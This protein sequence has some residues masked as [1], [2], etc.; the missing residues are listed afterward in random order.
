M[1]CSSAS[2]LGH[3]L[4]S[5]FQIHQKPLAVT[6]ASRKAAVAAVTAR[7]DSIPIQRFASPLAALRNATAV[8]FVRGVFT[9]FVAVAIGIL[10]VSGVAGFVA[11]LVAHLI[12]SGALLLRMKAAPSAYFVQQGPLGFL[13]SG[14]SDNLVL[15]IF[16]WT[17]AYAVVHVY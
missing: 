14:L 11:Y 4:A 10:G 8:G 2:S 6:M 15:F 12:A 7:S 13:F 1:K 16:V 17:L 9:S 5:T 3:E